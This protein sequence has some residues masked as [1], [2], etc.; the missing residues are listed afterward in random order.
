MELHQIGIKGVYLNGELTSE[1]TIYMHQPPRFISTEYP[2]HV[3]RPVKTLYSLKQ[4][5]CRWYQ[6]LVEILV[7]PLRFSQCNVNQAVFFRRTASGKLTVIMVHGD[8]CTIATSD[9]K[10]VESLKR[11]VREHVEM[12]DLGELHWLLGIEIR[13]N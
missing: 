1:E 13:R 4:S 8:N 3:C 12:T 11:G 5:G 7:G 2:N 10:S 6:K 9:L